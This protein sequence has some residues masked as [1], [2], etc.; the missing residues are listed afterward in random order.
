MKNKIN[1]QLSTF[2]Y[3]KIA[4]DKSQLVT[5][6]QNNL[7]ITDYQ[8]KAFRLQS[9]YPICK[10]KALPYISIPNIKSLTSYFQPPASSF[11]LLA[12]TLTNFIVFLILLPS[13]SF[14]WQVESIFGFTVDSEKGPVLGSFIDNILT[15]IYSIS[16]ILIML[17]IILA[18]YEYMTSQGN[19]QLVKVAKDKIWHAVQGLL[20][21]FS[22]FLFAKLIGGDLLINYLY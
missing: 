15:F 3:Q 9:I 14:A 12:I 1:C 2:S 6:E 7:Q 20:I 16:G 21:V 4:N 11:Q 22:A 19:P 8:K 5:T 17:R 13:T 18:G 10:A